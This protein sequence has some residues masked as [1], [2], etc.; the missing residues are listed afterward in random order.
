[1]PD[2]PKLASVPVYE[3]STQTVCFEFWDGNEKRAASLKLPLVSADEAIGFFNTNWAVIA[4]MVARTAPINGE[5]N[6]T[7]CS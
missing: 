1:M 5:V 2:K 3:A 7:L 4:G 6:L